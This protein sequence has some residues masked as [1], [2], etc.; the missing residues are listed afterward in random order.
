M[1]KQ[2]VDEILRFSR[3][4]CAERLPWFSPVIFSCKIHQTNKVPVAAIDQNLNI[5]FNPKAV[6]AIKNSSKDDKDALAQLGFLW[7]HE[8]SHI[9]RDHAER[10]K[11]NGVRPDVW[12]VAADLEINDS[13]WQGLRAP[14]VFPGQFPSQYKFPE[15]KLAEEYYEMLGGGKPDEDSNKIIANP[16]KNKS[17]DGENKSQASSNKNEEGNQEEEDDDNGQ[18]DQNE[19][20]ENGQSEPQHDEGS[21]VHGQPRPWEVSDE[22]EGQSLDEMELER[23]RRSVAQE[24]KTSETMG[25]M[26]GSW[27]RWIDDKLEPKIDWRKKLRHRMSVAMA[28]GM[29][30][31]ADFSFARP[32]RRQSVYHPIIPPALTG[33]RSARVTVVV[34]TSGS[35]GAGL[36]TQCVAE[37]CNVLEAFQVPVTVIPCDA[38]A[39]EPIEIATRSDYFKLEKLPGGGG[40]NMIVGIEAAL[41]LKPKPDTVLVLTDG[42]TPYPKR[43]YKTPVLFGVFQ[44][45]R[46][47]KAAHPPLPWRSDMVVDIWMDSL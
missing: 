22:N 36:L 24:M 40:T 3:A 1:T 5:Y 37:V 9:L 44:F 10:A 30:A 42:Y 35:M 4:Y 16:S 6:E 14:Q 45:D 41:K 26:P 2:E 39:Y 31:R 23:I 27:G 11:D 13:H 19:N 28:T 17:D 43:L 47:N 33:D 8:V 7:I 21:G 25:D 12:N 18:N 34:D 46:R 38:K 32:S 29:G 20:D 15:G